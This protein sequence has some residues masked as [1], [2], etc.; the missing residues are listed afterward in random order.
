MRLFRNTNVSNKYTLLFEHIYTA[1]SKYVLQTTKRWIGL[2]LLIPMFF[3]YTQGQKSTVYGKVSDSQSGEPLIFATVQ[4]KGTGGGAYTDDKGMYRLVAEGKADTLIF[5]YLGYRQEKRAIKTGVEQELN[6]SM[7]QQN[8]SLSD[9]II[10][11]PAYPIMR[12]AIGRKARNNRFE[13]PTYE[14]EAYTKIEI[15]LKDLTEKVRNK[16]IYRPF[17]R[18]FDL[19]D[20]TDDQGYLPIFF[21]ETISQFYYNKQPLKLHERIKATKTAGVENESF[22]KLMGDTHVSINVYD[23]NIVLLLDKPFVSPVSRA[24]FRYYEYDLIDSLKLDGD[25]CYHIRFYPKRKQELTFAGDIW[26]EQHT[27]GVKK[28][29]MSLA[30]DININFVKKLHINQ[31][32]KEVQTNR[33]M[34]V[35]DGLEVEA[36]VLIPYEARNQT[37]IA[38]KYSEYVGHSFPEKLPTAIASTSDA[39]SMDEEAFSF[40]DDFWDKRRPDSLTKNEKLAY[41]LIDSV[42]QLPAYRFFRTIARGYADFGKIEIGPLF[43]FYGY[44]PIEGLRLKFGGRYFTGSTVFSTYAAYGLND[45]EW[46]YGFRFTR[47]LNDKPWQ[48]LSASHARDVEQLGGIQAFLYDDNIL[49][50]V[51]MGSLGNRLQM[52]TSYKASYEREWL[53]GFSNILQFSHKNAQPLGELSYNH[54][55]P[56]GEVVTDLTTTEV[57]LTTHFAWKEEF[58]SDGLFRSSLGSKYPMLNAKYTWGIKD[59]LGSDFGFHK[60]V[61]GVQHRLPLGR[62]GYLDYTVEGGK[63]WGDVL[64]PL[65]LVPQGNETPYLI[66][67]AFNNMAFFEFIADTYVS[68]SATYH[69]EGL[70]FNHIP[71]LRK[72]KWREV[73]SGKM[74]AGSVTG[75]HQQ[76]TPFPEFTQALTYPYY[77][78]SVGIKN[79]FTVLRIDAMWRLSYLDN[80]RARNF[81]ILG[82]LDFNF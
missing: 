77:E 68:G 66:P 3:L 49:S 78:A 60:L 13:Y 16:A 9:V 48:I 19:T 32:Y 53:P 75:N 74:I 54:Q 11:P 20:S 28:V 73:V 58:Y 6:V 46:K 36:E 18:V 30:E 63:V 24:G 51:F 44:N 5:T 71:L 57:S 1:L 22:A 67:T 25:Y 59:A 43:T 38:K 39:V 40:E 72:L 23:D 10:E 52:V 47:L 2:A 31:E 21:T 64:F 14:Y 29:D 50:S 8:F 42:K 69:M 45:E 70:I 26:I 34:P 82:R 37:F 61:L 80:D 56:D 15:G 7:T 79:I 4:L 12:K 27:Y 81:S 62:L 65:L 55:G 41:G 76:I 17:K 35:K 33:W